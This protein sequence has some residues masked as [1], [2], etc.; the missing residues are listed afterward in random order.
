MI[1]PPRPKGIEH[2]DTEHGKLYYTS[3]Q[4]RQYGLQCVEEYK[5]CSPDQKTESVNP[6]SRKTQSC[7]VVDELFGRMGMR[8]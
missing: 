1:F 4:L 8:P 5:R 7:G 2:D 3:E 6:L